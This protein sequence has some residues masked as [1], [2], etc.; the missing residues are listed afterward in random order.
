MTPLAIVAVAL[1]GVLWGLPA[2]G[3][4]SAP[5]R[6]DR[7]SEVQPPRPRGSLE[8]GM[9]P[10]IAA[11]Y[12]AGI[13][14]VRAG[15]YRAALTQVRRARALSYRLSVRGPLPRLLAHRYLVRTA[16]VEVQLTELLAIDEQLPRVAERVDDHASLLQLRAMILH[17][18]FLAV[19]S[20]TGQSD[21]RLMRVTVAAYEVS[22]AELGGHLRSGAQV[23]Y[24][25]MLGERGELRAARS[26]F[27][28]IGDKEVHSEELD[29]PVA[30]YHLAVGERGRALARLLLAA[31]RDSWDRPGALRDGT[32]VRAQ[33]Y[34]MNDFDR[35]RDHPR[36]HEMVTQPEERLAD[37]R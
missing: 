15:D 31:R 6:G 2:P 1:H 36:F 20:Y 32:T 22:L 17:N 3:P 26:E 5:L 12:A 16:F 27:A 10:E 8:D 25:A 29:L 23:G 7:A 24:A 13:A 28:K 21:A 14:A 35:L 30:Y 4:E 33:A 37:G 34:R 18:L 19:R 11:P 9:P